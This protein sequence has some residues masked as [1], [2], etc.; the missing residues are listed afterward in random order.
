MTDNAAMWT[1]TRT[2]TSHVS[3]RENGTQTNDTAQWTHKTTEGRERE[4]G[5]KCMR[6][7]EGK[8]EG[9]R[10]SEAMA[11]ED[12]MTQNPASETRKKTTQTQTD[13][14]TMCNAATQTQT[15]TTSPQLTHKPA[16]QVNDATLR[17]GKTEAQYLQDTCTHPLAPH[18]AST[19]PPSV[20]HAATPHASTHAPTRKTAG[21][22][23]DA[24]RQTRE[25]REWQTREEVWTRDR[26]QKE[27]R[28]CETAVQTE[29]PHAQ[30]APTSARQTLA[31]T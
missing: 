5:E 6:E 13:A 17:M 24:A 11:K 1:E 23:K 25:T 26:S 12:T 9:T 20:P 15:N 10:E 8:E 4:K 18:T 31:P 22:M 30:P 19:Q 27:T 14:T 7:V 29:P 21:Q 2:M 28:T 16:T 3:T